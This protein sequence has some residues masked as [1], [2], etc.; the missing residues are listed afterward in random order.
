[1]LGDS[2]KRDNH[3]A[4][5]DALAT[6]DANFMAV[7]GSFLA[8]PTTCFPTMSPITPP[9]NVFDTASSAALVACCV[10]G[11]SMTAF[12]ATAFPFFRNPPSL[13]F[14][15]AACSR[16]WPLTELTAADLIAPFAIPFAMDAILIR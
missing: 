7:F 11:F 3:L 10:I 12:S 8:S 5:F 16:T 1:M 2:H 6:V 13:E 14:S 4:F 15:S 9:P